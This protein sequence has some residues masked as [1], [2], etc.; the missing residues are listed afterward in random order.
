MESVDSGEQSR[1]RLPEEIKLRRLVQQAGLAPSGDNNQPWLFRLGDDKIL[2]YCV[3]ERRIY[4]D[5][6]Q[7]FNYLSLGMALENLEIAAAYEN[8]EVRIQYLEPTTAADPVAAISFCSGKADSPLYHYIS[9]RHTNRKW[10][11]KDPLPPDCLA[12]MR[13]LAEAVDVGFSF[14]AEREKISEVARVVALCDRLR[15]RYRSFH[16]EMVK[17]LR[18]SQREA[19]TRGDGIL[20]SSLELIPPGTLLPRLISSWRRLSL[21]NLLGLSRVISSASGAQVVHS[22]GVGLISVSADRVLDFLRA[23]KAFQAIWLTLTKYGVSLHPLGSYSIFAA[24]AEDPESTLSEEDR[25]R[26]RSGVSSFG[27]VFPETRGMVPV[28]LFRVGYAPR[29]TAVSSH[30][31]PLKQIFSDLQPEDD[32]VFDYQ[33]AF[34][35]NVGLVSRSE[36]ERLRQSTVAIPGLGGVGGIHLAT[37]TRMGIGGFHLADFDQFSV[38]NFN[39]QYGAMVSTLD[40]DKID[41]MA[42]IAKDINPELRLRSWREGVTEENVE[43]FLTG[44]DVVVDSLDAYCVKARRMLFSKAQAMGVPIISAGPIGCSCALLEFTPDSMSFDDYFDYRESASDEENFFKF[45]LGVIP[46]LE[47]FRYLDSSEIRTEQRTGPSLAPAVALC[48]GFAG[49]EVLKYLLNRKPLYSVPYYHY[50]DSYLMKFKRRYMPMGNRNPVQRL[51][52]AMV[53]RRVKS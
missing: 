5:K 19:N 16:D 35:R 8:Y 51:K 26:I 17:I 47:P 27:E 22:G 21:L 36:Q 18:Y 11:K 4:S 43:Q 34:S 33:T 9:R 52:F 45:V 25:V 7:M 20:V 1:L 23:G 29:P 12:Q 31:F 49:V 42:G 53:R 2:L 13:S 6:R 39:R 41:V 40:K 30:R 50:Y 48:A 44:V 10:Y 28:I 37:L 14:S 3:E 38:G 46:G 24:L 15:F 32:G